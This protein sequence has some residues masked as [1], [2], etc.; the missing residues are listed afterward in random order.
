MKNVLLLLLVLRVYWYVG[1]VKKSGDVVEW[2]CNGAA[3]VRT[4]GGRI[5]VIPKSE[6]A[7]SRWVEK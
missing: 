1:D 4:V 2:K 6:I 3:I 7:A 5:D